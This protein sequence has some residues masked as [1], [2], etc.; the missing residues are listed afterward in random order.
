[1]TWATEN[2]PDGLP[3]WRGSDSI[4]NTNREKACQVKG[5]ALPALGVCVLIS[6]GFIVGGSGGSTIDEAMAGL[7][8]LL[9]IVFGGAF[10]W[11]LYVWPALSVRQWFAPAWELRA[12]VSGFEFKREADGLRDAA[13]WSVQ[14]AGVSRV[15][16]GRSSQWEPG[17]GEGLGLMETSPHESQAFLFMADGSRRVICSVNA[18]HEVTAM[19]AHSVREWLEAAKAEALAR[20]RSPVVS[21]GRSEGFDV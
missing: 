18:N 12:T 8:W 17:R 16:V 10:L 7:G 19:L 1:M 5:C 14:L 11:L 15:E 6:L 2:G 13:S 9:L 20:E 3:I 21:L 4:A